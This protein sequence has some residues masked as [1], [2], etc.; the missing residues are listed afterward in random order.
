MSQS[1][2][3][4]SEPEVT[5]RSWASLAAVL[6]V[7]A[8]NAFN[9]NFVKLA[10]IT[11]TVTV[12]AGSSLAGY[13]EHILGAMI[14]LPFILLAPLAGWLS[15]R[16]AKSFVI[17]MAVIAKF[18]IFVLFIAALMLRSLPLALAADFLFVVQSTLFSP[19]KFGILKEIVGSKRLGL[20]NGLVQM[21]TMLGI[22]GGMAIG[23]WWFDHE[24]AL[25]NEAG[26]LSVDSGWGAGLHLFLWGAAAAL[27]PIV[28]G[29][30]IQKTPEHKEKKFHLSVLGSHFSDLRYLISQ[31][32]LRRTV[33]FIAGYW[34][35]ANFLGL[36][37]IGF[38][39]ELHPDTAAGGVGVSS[40]QMLTTTGVGLA[41]GSLI[42]SFLCRKGNKLSLPIYG[43][44]AMIVGLLAMG[45]I[46]PDTRQWFGSI[47]LIGFASSF[48]LVPLSTHLQDMV[49]ATH[50][51]QVLAAQNLVI[52][53]S[54]IVAIVINAL[55]KMAGIPMAVQ[56]LALA[57]AAAVITLSL[58]HLLR[59][60]ALSEVRRVP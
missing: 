10:L 7:Q 21:L 15:D 29:L 30:F 1:V 16:Y 34:F 58:L 26:G 13:I 55:L 37:F 50:R 38:A 59:T 60:T 39:K 2:A 35:V 8:Q 17:Y 43:G 5:P 28:V 47:A 3:E 41:V 56:T 57:V 53:L 4:P 20:A 11:L 19:A 12:A 24:Y 18:L 54:G 42:V 44:A 33:I 45:T 31:P 48:F 14:P 27:I 6:Y 22:L 46:T 49:A 52:S 40:S 25:R 51:G 9:D 36:V 32:I 23:G